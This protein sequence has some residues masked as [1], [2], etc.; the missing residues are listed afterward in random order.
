VQALGEQEDLLWLAAIGAIGD[1]ADESAFPEIA[2]AQKRYGKTALRDAVSLVNAPRRTAAAD[3]A[4]ALR[5]L[6]ESDGPKAITKGDSKDAEALRA[7][8]PRCA[9]R[10]RRRSG[11]H[12]SCATK[13][14]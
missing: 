7:A 14:R 9:P 2:E 5:L 4:P 13:W 12:P 6:L 1:M 8:K 11:P 10:W 3:A